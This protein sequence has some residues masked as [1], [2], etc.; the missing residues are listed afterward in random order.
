MDIRELKQEL[1]DGKVR[2]FYVFTGDELALQDLYIHKIEEVSGL[3]S[4]RVDTVAGILSSLM[5]KS[6]FDTSSMI[7]VIRNDDTYYKSEST[8]KTLLEKKDF[9]GNIVILLYSGIDKSNNFTKQ[10]DAVLTKFD[11]MT[12]SILKNRLQA[13]TKMPIQYCEDLVKMC[14][15]NYG[16]IQNELTKLY[17]LARAN[18]YSLNN[19]Y[20]D[21]KKQ[22]MIHEDIGD[23]IFDYTNAVIH[24]NIKKAYE[25]WPKMKYTGDGPMRVISV[26]YN[27]FRQ[28]LMVQSTEQSQ[29]TEQ[30]LGMTKGQIYVTSQQ[31][32]IYNL[33]ELVFIVKTLRYLEKGIKIGLV[34]E[35]FAIPYFMGVI[36]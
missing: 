16:R 35:E 3:K 1:M 6:L 20:L 28:I 25:L 26:L 23:I 21:A 32:N 36:W 11:F 29:R 17:T 5:S 24:R 10:H 2:H 30:V 8:W 9:L 27:S 19:A 22:N 15:N 31:C 33:F 12:G 14:G 34:A 7:Y 18:N 4:M 13:I